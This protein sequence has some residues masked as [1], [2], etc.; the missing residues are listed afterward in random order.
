[1]MRP[2]LSINAGRKH[3]SHSPAGIAAVGGRLIANSLRIFDALDGAMIFIKATDN[4]GA[5]E[6]P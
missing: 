1:M 6:S 5:E 2:L 3:I 4:A